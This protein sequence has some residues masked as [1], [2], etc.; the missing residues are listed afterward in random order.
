MFKV[1]KTLEQGV[2][3]PNLTIKT[4]ERSHWPV[5][6]G[7]QAAEWLKAQEIRKLG[8]FNKYPDA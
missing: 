3:C 1:N 8:N 5:N 4:L 7:W 6:D 2:K